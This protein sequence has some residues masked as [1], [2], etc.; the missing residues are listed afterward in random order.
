MDYNHYVAKKNWVPGKVST[1]ST[2][3]WDLGSAEMPLKQIKHLWNV[4]ELLCHKL[5]KK[6]QQ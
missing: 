6:I 5:Y 2:N 1:E 4:K 3:S